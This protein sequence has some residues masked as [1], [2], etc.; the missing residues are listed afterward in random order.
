MNEGLVKSAFAQMLELM[1]FAP[2]V[3]PLPKGHKVVEWHGKSGNH[4]ANYHPSRPRTREWWKGAWGA[5]KAA[6]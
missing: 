4:P 5:G 1:K 3:K 2:R 6:A